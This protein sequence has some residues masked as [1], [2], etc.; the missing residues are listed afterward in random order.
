MEEVPAKT[1]E[2]QA[3]E[4]AQP[5]VKKPSFFGSLKRFDIYIWMIVVLSILAA[6]GIYTDVISI[7]TTPYITVIQTLVLQL[8]VAVVVA[9]ITD[10]LAKFAKTKQFKI[11]KTGII[12]GLFIGS[13]LTEGTPLQMVALAAF[14]AELL[15][16]LIRYQG[17]NIFNPTVL[18]LLIMSVV[19]NSELSWWASSS[20]PALIILGLFISYK[21]KRFS[22]TLPAIVFYLFLI[23][24]QTPPVTISNIISAFE[25][26]TF[27]F[28]VFFMVVEP[29]SSPVFWKSRIA[30]GLTVA[31]LLAGILP[32]VS[33][34]FF[35]NKVAIAGMDLSQI[36][37]I[38]I[39]FVS[40]LLA[41]ALGR[42]Y[43][44]LIK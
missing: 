34:N 27:L 22:L 44:K 15:K 35:V 7:S 6:F 20:L 18:S 9:T 5:E 32:W 13:L 40:L 11:S 16:H 12:T 43:E 29:K 28:F 4:N 36:L 17:R 14:L 1:Q 10:M 19:F 37:S 23:V 26:N 2:N 39:Y 41:N 38:N 33:A 25:N 21:Y 31:F 30:Y 3:P 42:V 24:F 8:A